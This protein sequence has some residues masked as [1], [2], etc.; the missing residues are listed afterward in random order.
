[1]PDMIG[2]SGSNERIGAVRRFNRFYTQRL[3][4]LQDGWLDSSFSLTEARVLYE[5]TRRGGATAT[6]IGAALGLDAG[7]LSRILRAFQSRGLISRKTSAD[8]ARQSRIALTA[9]GRKV[10]AP[11]ERH[12]VEEIGATLKSLSVIDRRRLVAAMG[13][14]ENIPGAPAEPD[15]TCRLRAPRT[16]DF[17][18]IVSRHGELYAQEYDWGEPFEGLCAQIVADFANGHDPKRER[19]WIADYRGENVGS[20]MLVKDSEEIARLRLLLVDPAARGLGLGTKLV[21]ECV[22]FARKAGYR[23]IT[24]WTHSVL[25]AARKIYERAGFTLTASEE[26]MSWGQPVVAEYWDLK[27]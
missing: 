6:E 20:V 3:G 26:K 12:T 4:V 1:M 14:I 7:Y 2:I 13:P 23:G 5:L 25:I 8:D 11:L 10:F 27:L 19:C 22:T 15:E 9:R 17:G 21:D 24:L 18:W 16:G